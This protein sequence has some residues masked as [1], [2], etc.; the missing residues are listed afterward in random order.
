MRNLIISLV[1]LLFC[2]MANGQVVEP[3]YIGRA[4]MQIDNGEIID[5]LPERFFIKDETKTKTNA[6][7]LKSGL[8]W[9]NSKSTN[10]SR[11][12]L[13]GV[14]SNSYVSAKEGFSII[15]RVDDNRY[16]PET[17]FRVVRLL[18][19]VE[20]GIRYY[21]Y[22]DVENTV[23]VEACRYGESSYLIRFKEPQSGE[24][25]IE[26]QNDMNM[27]ITF[28]VIYKKED[29]WDYVRAFMKRFEGRTNIDLYEADTFY[30]LIFDFQTDT[31]LREDAFRMKYGEQFTDELYVAYRALQKE[32]RQAKKSERQN[33]KKQKE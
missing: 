11:V 19:N 13:R 18:W 24:F 29:A 27:L 14:A 10:H 25:A 26:V 17:K 5:L 20:K 21:T 7:M 6:V 8:G 23:P 22:G 3:E 2:G 15:L 16:A 1:L 9:A 4:F 33:R 12:E 32:A 30:K 28:G 31:H